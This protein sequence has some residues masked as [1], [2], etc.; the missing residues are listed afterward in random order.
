M[1][2]TMPA[3]TS[4]TTPTTAR[5]PDLDVVLDEYRVPYRFVEQVPIG[6][7]RVDPAAQVRFDGI[8]RVRDEA[9]VESLAISYQRANALGHPW[10]LPPL[11]ALEDGSIVDGNGR[12]AGATKAGV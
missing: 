4:T 7:L 1:T 3:S 5:R 6:Q 10:T 9:D 2:M 8:D 12:Y 11:F